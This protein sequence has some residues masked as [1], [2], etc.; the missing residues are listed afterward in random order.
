MYRK[1]MTTADLGVQAPGS[2]SAM[3]LGI[4]MAAV[5]ILGLINPVVAVITAGIWIVAA[6]IL[7][8]IRM[9]WIAR[10]AGVLG[11]SSE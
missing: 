1:A 3:V 11:E 10:S 7:S 4:A 8:G 5:G 9:I 6:L 2:V